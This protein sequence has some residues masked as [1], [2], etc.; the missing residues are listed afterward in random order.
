V[1]LGTPGYTKIKGGHLIGELAQEIGPGTLT[2]VAA[3]REVHYNST[4]NVSGD[5]FDVLLFPDGDEDSDQRSLEAR[6]NVSFGDTVDLLIGAFWFDLDSNV[7]E[8]RLQRI[9]TSTVNKIYSVNIWDQSTRSYAGF[10]NVDIHITPELTLSGGLRYSKD[11]KRMHIVPLAACPGQ[12]YETCPRNFLDAEKSWDDI[13][14]RIVANYKVTPDI[15][16]YGSY[17]KGYRAG[18]FNARAPSRLG[19]VTPADPE[20]VSSY[21][22]GFKSDLLDNHL[23]FNLGLFRQKYDDIQRLV[24]VAITGSSPLQLLFN[25]AKATIQGVEIETSVLPFRGLRLDANVGYTDAKYDEF[26]NLTGLAPGQSPTDLEF[27][28]VPKWTVYLGGSYETRMGEGDQRLSVDAG[29][30]WRSGVF[31]DVLNTRELRQEAYG[32]F[33]AS[34]S[35]RTGPWSVSVFG[36]NIFDKEYA[37]IKSAGLGYN[38]F[39]GTRRYYGVEAGYRF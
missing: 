5:P 25:A 28:R 35:Y 16:L 19:A 18:N 15:M 4:L 33:N 36:R 22:V 8:K 34:A 7:F 6:Y 12:G 11:R 38:A 21:E 27:D 37:E 29:W 3:Y 1:N 10:A 2:A 13:S 9:P 39:G 31:M 23:R 24:Q 20:T 32:L 17:S 26:N 30:T 14:P